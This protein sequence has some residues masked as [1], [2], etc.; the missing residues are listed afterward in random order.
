MVYVKVIG[1]GPA[2]TV[3]VDNNSYDNTV[4]YLQD[5]YNHLHQ[6]KI[7][8]NS[9]NVGFGKAINQAAVIAKGDYYFFL[10]PDTI[11]Q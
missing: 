10:N 6:I 1:L 5:R 7:I 11:I 8:K 3:Q 9:D 4:A 2:K